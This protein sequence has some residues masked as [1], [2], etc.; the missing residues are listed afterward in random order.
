VESL[1]AKNGDEPLH[2]EGEQEM[3]SQKSERLTSALKYYLLYSKN[4]R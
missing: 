3:T 2:A 4:D 1:I